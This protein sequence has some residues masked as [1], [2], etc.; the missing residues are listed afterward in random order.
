MAYPTYFVRFERVEGDRLTLTVVESKA[1]NEGSPGS[2][3][4]DLVPSKSL[5]LQFL[6]VLAEGMRGGGE[7]WRGQEAQVV[8]LPPGEAERLGASC[9]LAGAGLPGMGDDR[10]DAY[11]AYIEAARARAGEFVESVLITDR[12]HYCDGP[13]LSDEPRPQAT[14]I[15]VVTDPRWLAHVV[16]GAKMTTLAMPLE[17]EYTSP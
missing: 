3:G 4:E 17:P 11:D 8:P 10:Y 2:G 15:V 13:Y 1:G 7:T 12:R 9:P 14:Y 16:V 6:L 5:V